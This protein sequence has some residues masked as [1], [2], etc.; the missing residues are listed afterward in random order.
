MSTLPNAERRKLV[1]KVVLGV[2]EVRDY[3]A[4]IHGAIEERMEAMSR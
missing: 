2:L 3:K 4:A 1:I